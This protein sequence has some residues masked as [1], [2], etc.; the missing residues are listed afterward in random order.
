[1]TRRQ[2]VKSRHVLRTLLGTHCGGLPNVSFPDPNGLCSSARGCRI[3]PC[4]SRS[5]T[6]VVR[7]QLLDARDVF[8]V[9]IPASHERPELIVARDVDP[10]QNRA[11]VRRA[12]CHEGPSLEPTVV[13]Q[14]VRIIGDQVAVDARRGD[15][16]GGS[17][18][19]A[20]AL[21]GMISGL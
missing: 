15:R 10:S 12:T 8:L 3:T 7:I 18:L 9:R 21:L 13:E 6:W 16:A 4:H 19:S 11:F 17:A 5:Q 1:M 2:S 20:L 14:L